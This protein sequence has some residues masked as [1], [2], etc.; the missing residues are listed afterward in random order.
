MSRAKTLEHVGNQVAKLRRKNNLSQEKLAELV[1]VHRNHIGR[2][3]R[4]ETNIPILTLLNLC[5]ALK[6]ESNEILPF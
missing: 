5:K 3:E 2:I 6:V 1:N 4:G